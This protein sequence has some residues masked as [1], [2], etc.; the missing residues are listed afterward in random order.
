MSPQV[1]PQRRWQPGFLS[2][3]GL[4]MAVGV[5]ALAVINGLTAAAQSG[6]TATQQLFLPVIRTRPQTW[7]PFAD[8][9]PW[10]VRI[11]SN[12]SV[13]PRSSVMINQLLAV[14][15]ISG[16]W[17]NLYD[18]TV[19]IWRADASTPYVSVSC[20]PNSCKDLASVP[21]PA[22]AVPDPAS[23]GHM[24][25][26]DAGRTRAW[27]FWRAKKNN[28]GSWS[29]GYG[30]SFDLFG[31]GVR[32]R[33]KGSARA[34]GLPLAGGL[35][36]LDE[37]KAGRIEHALVFNYD[38]PMSCL[39]YPASTNGNNSDDPDSIPFGARLQLDP[40]LDL[41]TLGLTPAA[42]VIAR[43]MQEY[44]LILGDGGASYIT[45]YAESFYGKSGGDPWAS[46]LKETD[47]LK[48]PLNR[49]RVLTLGPVDCVPD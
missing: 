26:I 15:P 47:L 42:K 33:G 49:L 21:I 39:V 23:Q 43:A 38:A 9:S 12:A 40:T 3:R 10:N 5:L 4:I 24:M 34:S 22:N 46:V 45:L 44:G 2:Q 32:P 19:P 16:F 28:D 29:A 17:I 48:I 1:R 27:D 13:D 11:A 6:E 14:T 20:A 37:V 7:R 41:D 30:A 36:Y 18:V 31:E 35:V 8:T 25:V